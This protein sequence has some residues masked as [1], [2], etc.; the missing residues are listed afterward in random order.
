VCIN[1]QPGWSAEAL[2]SSWWT[3]LC[4]TTSQVL[5]WDIRG[6]SFGSLLGTGDGDVLT[7]AKINKTGTQVAAGTVGGNVLLWDLRFSNSPCEVFK[8]GV[9]TPV[10]SIAFANSSSLLSCGARDGF[11]TTWDTTTNKPLFL[12]EQMAATSRISALSFSQCDS[13]LFAGG[14]GSVSRI[15]MKDLLSRPV[16]TLLVR[17]FGTKHV[18]DMVPLEENDKLL[19]AV[20]EYETSI[21]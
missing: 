5:L 17:N 9:R 4:S 16:E 20:S 21:V 18:R 19:L 15:V 14:A 8:G 7:T 2:E 11:V 13:G 1:W 3:V 10:T 6:K 12:K